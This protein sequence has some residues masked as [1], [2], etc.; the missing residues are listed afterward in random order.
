MKLCDKCKKRPAVVFISDQN[1]PNSAPQGL[2]LV[3]AKQAGIK[4]IDDMLKNMNISDDDIDQISNQVMEIMGDNPDEF[5]L[6]TAPPF[7]FLNNIFGDMSANT[8][9]D[10]ENNTE[11]EKDSKEPK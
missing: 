7:P 1:A 5:D 4:P 11:K 8:E 2:C 3:C 9:T 6:G 10:A